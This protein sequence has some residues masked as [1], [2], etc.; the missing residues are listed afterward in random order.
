MCSYNYIYFNN[1]ITEVIRSHNE[2]R[3]RQSNH[4]IVSNK[5]NEAVQM[6]QKL[7]EFSDVHILHPI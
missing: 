6:M 7:L 5:L 1:E 4:T 3:D 2:G